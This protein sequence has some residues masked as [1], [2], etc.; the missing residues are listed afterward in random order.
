MI[1]LVDRHGRPLATGRNWP[2][3]DDM[4]DMSGVHSLT[5]D[6][7]SSDDRFEEYRPFRIHEL[8]RIMEKEHREQVRA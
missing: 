7:V 1:D 6:E 8:M 5:I 4:L 2:W 3:W